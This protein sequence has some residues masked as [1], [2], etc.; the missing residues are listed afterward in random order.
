[1][2]SSLKTLLEQMRI[3]EIDIG[4]RKHLL[5]FDQDDVDA[6]LLCRPL[7]DEKLDDI[8]D[9]FYG[10]Q[11][12]N[13]EIAALIGDADTL[14]RLQ[15]AQRRYI[16]DLF[17][18]VY[19]LEYTNNRLRIGLVHKR[20]GVELK[21]YLSAVYLLRRLLV[22]S[23]ID[24]LEDS[25]QRAAAL[26]ALDKLIYFDVTLV[27]ETYIQS[28]LSEIEAVKNRTEKYAR[29]LEETVAM[30][31]GQLRTDALTGLTTRRYLHEGLQRA[32]HAAQRRNEPL[33][34]IFVDVDNFKE[35][36]DLRGHAYGDRVLCDL[37]RVLMETA[38]GEDTCVR[39]G[40]DEFCVVLAN[41]TEEQ[42]RTSFCERVR[43]L[44]AERLP[45]VS[46]SMGIVQ[47]GPEHYESADVL[48]KSAD[49]RMYLDK[50]DKKK[51]ATSPANGSGRAKSAP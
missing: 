23:I 35:L 27:F 8:V 18:G 40:G 5:E 19:D 36:N 21:L 12:S 51:A 42:S 16:L 2:H 48:L 46:I 24:A 22:S 6:L 7:V 28:M 15:S 13:L 25:E 4:S 17:A 39:Y 31:N 33:S 29:A 32:L 3:T 20:I 45:G 1:M 26:T 10:I 37:G 41:S 30:R 44:L 38:R 14:D 50:T 34:L 11:T 43:L 47:T 49:R 9:T